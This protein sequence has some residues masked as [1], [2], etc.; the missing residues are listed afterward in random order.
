VVYF[1]L[2]SIRLSQEQMEDGAVVF[3]VFKCGPHWGRTQAVCSTAS[4]VFNWEVGR[5]WSLRLVGPQA[6]A[7]ALQQRK[8]AMC[9]KM[10]DTQV[11]LPVYDPYTLLNL[12]LFSDSAERDPSVPASLVGKMRIRLSTLQPATSFKVSVHLRRCIKAAL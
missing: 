1:V 11:H 10:I 9:D 4:P 3:V 12:C 8:H 2:E 5:L 6:R 7:S